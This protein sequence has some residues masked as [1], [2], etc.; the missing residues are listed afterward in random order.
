ME[1]ISAAAKGAATSEAAGAAESEVIAE[2]LLRE[3]T[4]EHLTLLAATQD[5]SA[6]SAILYSRV[7]LESHKS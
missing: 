7:V 1:I 2:R 4:A 5:E 6:C 3:L